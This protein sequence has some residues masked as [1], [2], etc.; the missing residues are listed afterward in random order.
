[1][2]LTARKNTDAKRSHAFAPNDEAI[3]QSLLRYRYLSAQQICRLLYSFPGSLTYAQ[4]TLKRLTDSGYVQRLFVPRFGRY[5]SSP[6]AYRLARKGINHLR[7][8]GL[9]TPVRYRPSDGRTLSYLFLRHS[10]DVASVLMLGELL[11]RQCPPLVLETLLHDEDFKR[12]PIRVKDPARGEQLTVVPD[13]YW[14][15]RINGSQQVCVALEL[16]RGSEASQAWRRKIRGWVAAAQGPYQERLQTSSLTVVV[17]A[18][19]GEKRVLELKRWT[20]AELDEL[21]R[22]HADLFRFGC[23]LEDALPAER[24]FFASRFYRPFDDPRYPLLALAS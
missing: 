14:D 17:V 4:T 8:Q 9:E 13:G 20:E 23:L 24:F 18:T 7:D 10:L 2:P 21:G 5:G 16:D 1:M 6:C 19:P 11:A 15:F 22:G 12:D 3:L